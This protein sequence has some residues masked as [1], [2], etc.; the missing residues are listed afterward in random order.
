MSF[1][2]GGTPPTTAELAQRYK[3]HINKSIRAL[4]RE[5]MTNEEKVLMSEIK[6][7]SQNNIKQSMQKA[8]AV[9]RGRR[10]INKFSQMK[11]HLQGIASRMQINRGLAES[12]GS[13]S[14]NDEIFQQSG[15]QPFGGSTARI[16][17]TE[18]DD[19]YTRRND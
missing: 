8:Q 3:R 19:D 5:S 11:A 1:L 13:S 17:K 14:A 2:F 16:R 6:K 15:R 10:M 9:V 18:C 7:S 12:C 4:D